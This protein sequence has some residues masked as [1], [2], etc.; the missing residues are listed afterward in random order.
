MTPGFNSARFRPFGR[1]AAAILGAAAAVIAGPAFAEGPV[2]P[3]VATAFFFDNDIRLEVAGVISPRCTI[4]QSERSGSFGDVLDPRRGG[5]QAAELELDFRFACNSPFRVSMTSQ[6]GGLVTQA[7]GP[8]PF[9]NRLDYTAIVA[10]NDGRQ[11]D[12]CDSADMVLGAP[13]DERCVF[14]F[15]D[16]GGAS[17]PAKVRL[18]M[19]ADSTPLLGGQYADRLVVR[20]TPL[21]GGD[22]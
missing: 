17:G 9:R 10:L 15:E 7:R 13:R 12:A 11:T 2:D 3:R 4:D 8:A 19:T 6:N 20:I 5:N 22:D 14:R 1:R 16:A 18:S 21:L